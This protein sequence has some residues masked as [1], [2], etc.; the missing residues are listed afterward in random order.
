M[1]HAFAHGTIPEDSP[2][3]N[4]PKAAYGIFKTSVLSLKQI[5]VRFLRK[6]VAVAQVQAEMLGDARTKDPRHSFL[7][8][9]FTQEGGHWLIALAQNT[10][11][12]RPPELNQSKR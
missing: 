8:L 7:T 2:D 10:E 3:V 12:N 11:I 9:V 1:N 4:L 5:D 6:D